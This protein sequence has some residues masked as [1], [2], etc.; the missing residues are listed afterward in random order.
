MNRNVREHL[1]L[2]CF[3][4]AMF[5]VLIWAGIDGGPGTLPSKPTAHNKVH[6]W[7]R[8]D[9]LSFAL[10]QQEAEA[11]KQFICLSDLWGKESGW[12]PH[13]KNLI[14]S[15]GLNAGGIP[16][17]LGLSPSTPPSEQIRRGLRYISYRYITPC[18]AWQHWQKKGW[19]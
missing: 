7:T 4:A 13:A 11:Y 3:I 16:Q 12:N 15:Q 2:W 5:A 10:D 9:S 19:Y 1:P 8:Q 17:L 18:R 6:Q 14:K